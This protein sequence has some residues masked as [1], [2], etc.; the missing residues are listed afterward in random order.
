MSGTGGPGCQLGSTGSAICRDPA[1]HTYDYGSRCG[2]RSGLWRR[3]WRVAAALWCSPPPRCYPG[4][5][6]LATTEP[7]PGL[8]HV[9]GGGGV[10]ACV[11]VRVLPGAPGPAGEAGGA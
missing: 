7:W 2:R 6:G 3:L 11:R 8:S 1:L 10:G 4:R 5:L 9:G